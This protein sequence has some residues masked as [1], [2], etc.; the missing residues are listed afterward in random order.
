M[1]R[2]LLCEHSDLGEVRLVALSEDCFYINKSRKF[3]EKSSGAG[4]LHILSGD[5][6]KDFSFEGSLKE[7]ENNYLEFSFDSSRFREQIAKLLIQLRKN[8][9]IDICNTEDVE[10]SSRFTGFERLSFLPDAIPELSESDINTETILLGKRFAYPFFITGMT[11]GVSEGQRINE[12][13]AYGASQFRIPMGLGSQRLALE[14]PEYAKIFVLK[15]KFPDLFLFGN[16]G[17]SDLL[18]EKNPLDYC[19]RAIDMVR[20]DAFAIH[21]NVLQE[22]VQKEGNREFK[23][24]YKLIESLSSH[25][26]TPLIV[27]EVGSGVSSDVAKKLEGA[28]VRVLDVGGKGGTSWSQ[29]ESYRLSSEDGRLGRSF[30]NWGAPTA[31]TLAAVKN[32]CKELEVTATG[33]VRDGQT[34]AKACALGASMCGLGLPLFKAAV[35][36]SE[37]VI[38]ELELFSHQLKIT[39]LASGCSELKDLTTK[40]T[41]GEPLEKEFNSYLERL[42]IGRA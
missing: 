24:F 4:I 31:Y 15:E 3:S 19:R 9:H 42:G 25:L 37:D 17:F 21:L 14:H 29:V 40:L 10:S 5:G 33:G 36:S 12:N 39:L 2:P 16:I 20:A 30:R 38:R 13:L 23:G 27:K 7:A 26:E 22:C 11:G 1:Y 6:A 35:K 18:K 8:E 41:V 32:V 34:V 28:G